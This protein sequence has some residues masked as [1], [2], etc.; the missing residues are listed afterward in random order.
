MKV[1]LLYAYMFV[2]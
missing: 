1:Y 2:E